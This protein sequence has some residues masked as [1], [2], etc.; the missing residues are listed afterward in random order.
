[1]IYTDLAIETMATLQTLYG[2]AGRQVQGFLE[3]LFA[4]MKLDLS[5]PEHSTLSRRRGALA[6]TL[7]VWERS[8]PRHLV[9][10]STGVKVYGEG[11]WK[12]RQHGWSKRRTWRKLHLCVDAATL[13]IVSAVAS[14]NDLSDGAALPNLLA[15]VEGEAAQVSADGAYDRRQCYGTRARGHP[16]AQGGEDLAARHAAGRAP[17]AR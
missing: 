11:E 10:D 1:V 12:V 13:E 5:V 9:M 14:P 4:L 8:E 3:S 6:I 16:A 17:C 15:D 2:L 7:P